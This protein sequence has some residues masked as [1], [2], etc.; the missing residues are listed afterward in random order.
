MTTVKKEVTLTKSMYCESYLSNSLICKVAEYFKAER[1]RFDV[2][3]NSTQQPVTKLAHLVARCWK[4]TTYRVGQKKRTVFRLDN[5][6]TVSPRKACSM[7]KFSQF[8]PEK[9]RKL[10]FQWVKIFFAKFAQITTT[11]EIMLYMTRKHGFYSTY[12]NIQWNNCHFPT[13][14]VQMKLH[15]GTLC[16]DNH[17]QSFFGSWSIARFNVSWL[18]WAQQSISTRFSWSMCE[19]LRRYTICCN[20]PQTA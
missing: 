20:A 9:G 16:L 18:S 13:E 7:S 2:Q 17:H 4:T 8:Y 12:T 1:V 3:W 6:V 11:A 10:A 5:F 15:V 19:I 14:L